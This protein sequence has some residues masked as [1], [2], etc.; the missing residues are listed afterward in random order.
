MFMRTALMKRGQQMGL[1]QFRNF[2]L[3]SASQLGSISRD[4]VLGASDSKWIGSYA[5]AIIENGDSTGQHSDAL[6][7]YM[8]K[9]FR[10]LSTGQAMDIINSIGEDEKREPAACLDGKFW[11][12]ETLEEAVRP[13]IDTMSED[14]FYSCWKVF[15]RHYKGSQD[16]IDLV[17]QR[18]YNESDIFNDTK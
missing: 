4:Q 15:A 11:L 17:E 2:S 18:M 1:M 12:W 5:K 16:F 10:K 14:D 3:V 9:N 8:R 6:N 13:E 7:E